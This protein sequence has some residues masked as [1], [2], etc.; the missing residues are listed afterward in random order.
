MKEY[1]IYGRPLC[2][3]CDQAKRLLDHKEFPYNYVDARD[4][5]YFK[6]TFID[7]GIRTVPQIFVTELGGERHIGGFEELMK[8]IM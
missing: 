1:T 4:N 2:T 6:K 5:I 7:K 3:Y 8:E